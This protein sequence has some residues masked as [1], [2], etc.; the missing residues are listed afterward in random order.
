M[1]V[2]YLFK[3]MPKLGDRAFMAVV[4]KLLNILVHDIRNTTDFTLTSL[5]F[6]SKLMGKARIVRYLI[7]I[8]CKYII[9]G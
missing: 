8:L 6:L 1:V 4:L 9:D 2:K 3:T 7:L 5:Y